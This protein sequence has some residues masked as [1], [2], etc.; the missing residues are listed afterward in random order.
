MAD[1]SS[2]E[3]WRLD[4]PQF[5]ELFT[6]ES[7]LASDWYAARLDAKQAAARARAGEGL[8][9]I[10][11]FVSTPGN[12]EPTARLGMPARVEAARAEAERLAGSEFR[13]QLVGTS[14][15]TPL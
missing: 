2:R 9:V 8:A 12:E 6:R 15:S 11:R 5:R 14:G 3:G 13:D 7:V 1:G 10:E 4:S